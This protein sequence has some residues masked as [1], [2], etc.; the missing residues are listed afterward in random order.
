MA[1]TEDERALFATTQQ[2]LSSLD[3]FI[4]ELE[5]RLAEFEGALTRPDAGPE[6]VELYRQTRLH[7]DSANTQRT[8]FA[9]LAAVWCDD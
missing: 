1:A 3:G 4:S 2:T 6:L 8:E 9:E 5:V 7:L